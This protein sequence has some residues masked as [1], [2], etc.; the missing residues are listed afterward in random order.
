MVKTNTQ[1]YL[2]IFVA[3]N[4]P[5]PG[6]LWSFCLFILSTKNVFNRNKLPI[7]VAIVI[8]YFHAISC[9]SA[10]PS[11]HRLWKWLKF[12]KFLKNFE[13][14]EKIQKRL[15]FLQ[16]SCRCRPCSWWGHLLSKIFLWITI[17]GH[18]FLHNFL[19][20][21]SRRMNFTANF[22]RSQQICEGVKIT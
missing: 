3:L 14:L 7:K 20:S 17:A 15:N 10:H 18:F 16:I 21:I 6:F 2:K 5:S 13:I 4:C 22:Q 19:L 1:Q 12:W 8:I 9:K 11:F